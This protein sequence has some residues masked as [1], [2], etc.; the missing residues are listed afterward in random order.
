MSESELSTAEI[1]TPLPPKPAAKK[2]KRPWLVSLAA[3]LAAIGISVAIV[4]LRD[5]IRDF[6]IYG[7]P[8]VFLV[9]LIGN[10]TLILPAPSY[11]VVFA[12]GGALNPV[13]VG[14]VAGLG[15]A[16]GELTGYLAGV[17]GRVV[18]EDRAPYRRLEKRMHTKGGLVVIFLLA[19]VPNPAFDMG[20]I[21]AGTLRMPVWQFL[22]A[23]WAGKSIRFILL[24]F[25]GQFLLG[26]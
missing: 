24:A 4:L 12:V 5:H 25:S 18:V 14:I 15:A 22:L 10:A 11:A 2:K 26:S 8:G 19:L 7:Y 17:G 6:A 23:A 3:V 16:F 9:S 21:V 20:G 1:A 13:A